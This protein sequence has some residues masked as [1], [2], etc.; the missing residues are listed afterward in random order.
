[1]KID[2]NFKKSSTFQTTIFLTQNSHIFYILNNCRLKVKEVPLAEILLDKLYYIFK[3]QTQAT[4]I[5][6]FEIIDEIPPVTQKIMETIDPNKI[7]VINRDTNSIMPQFVALCNQNNIN[8]ICLSEHIKELNL[9][10]KDICWRYCS[11]RNIK[12]YR[13]LI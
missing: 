1:L 8:F 7:I 2:M 11:K 3:P 12:R 4:Q 6:P 9:T 5:H 13:K 10:V